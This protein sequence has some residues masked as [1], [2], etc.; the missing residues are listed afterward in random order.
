[1]AYW[2]CSHADHAAAALAQ[3]HCSTSPESQTAVREVCR[4]QLVA[5]ARSVHSLWYDD[6]SRTARKPRKPGRARLGH[7]VDI[8]GDRGSRPTELPDPF[9][10]CHMKKSIIEPLSTRSNLPF[11][12]MHHHGSIDLLTHMGTSESLSTYT[13]VH[14]RTS[15]C[16]CD[17]RTIARA[18]IARQPGRHQSL[19]PPPIHSRARGSPDR[20]HSRDPAGR[21]THRHTLALPANSRQIAEPPYRRR[22]SPSAPG[23]VVCAPTASHR[24]AATFLHTTRHMAVVSSSKLFSGVVGAEASRQALAAGHELALELKARDEGAPE[25]R[26]WLNEQIEEVRQKSGAYRRNRSRR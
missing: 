9:L 17:S 15:K 24:I 22:R 10:C 21:P 5:Y 8:L 7:T 13:S 11:S 2:H 25:G 26:S 3:D 19:E 18:R 6:R 23:A 14:M 16:E 12:Y 4:G 1:M 20:S